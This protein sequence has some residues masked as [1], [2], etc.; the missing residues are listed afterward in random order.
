MHN[1][2]SA[3]KC[4]KFTQLRKPFHV[5]KR[6]QL[7]PSYILMITE[8]W[9]TDSINDCEL[10]LKDYVIVCANLTTT[11]NISA[12]GGVLLGVLKPSIITP[13]NVEDLPDSCI[14][15]KFSCPSLIFI[16][17]EFYNPPMNSNYRYGQHNFENIRLIIDK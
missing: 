6:S 3:P 15:A 11:S 1:N 14:V 16:I 17:C 10:L 5:Y 9:L 7:Y 13:V 8:T 2:M 4:T 12:H